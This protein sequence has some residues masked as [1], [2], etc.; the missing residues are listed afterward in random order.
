MKPHL[1]TDNPSLITPVG[2]NFDENLNLLALYGFQVLIS[3]KFFY[4]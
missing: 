3:H 1:G 2:E 4:L